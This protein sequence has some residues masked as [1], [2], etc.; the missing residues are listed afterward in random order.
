MPLKEIDDLK[1]VVSTLIVWMAQSANSP[2]S[3]AE[4]AKL[5]GML[6]GGVEEPPEKKVSK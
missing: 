1:R 3:T 2:I 6:N 5:L 4:A